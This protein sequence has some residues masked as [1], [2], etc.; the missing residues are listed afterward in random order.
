MFKMQLIITTH[1]YHH[2]EPNKMKQNPSFS[3][4]P[5]YACCLES[6]LHPTPTLLYLANQIFCMV[7]PDIAITLCM[8]LILFVYLFICFVTL[9]AHL[10]F[11]QI[12]H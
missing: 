8:S 5:I 2:Q 1:L 4:F 11:I 10:S 6:L 3:L 12:D 9:C 7:L